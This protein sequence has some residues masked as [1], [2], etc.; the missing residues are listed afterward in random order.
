MVE[1]YRRKDMKKIALALLMV[2]GVAQAQAGD[3]GIPLTA[4]A[5]ASDT[6]SYDA[7]LDPRDKEVEEEY[8]IKG[9]QSVEQTCA[10]AVQA[11]EEIVQVSSEQWSIAMKIMKENGISMDALSRK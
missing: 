5:F 6:C 7:S 2:A 9:K 1:H 11:R 10:R 3:M 4:R 8:G